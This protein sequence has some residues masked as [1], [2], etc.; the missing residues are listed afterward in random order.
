[1]TEFLTPLLVFLLPMACAA[2]CLGPTPTD[3]AIAVFTRHREFVFDAPDATL[4]SPRLFAA[5]GAEAACRKSSPGEVCTL[6]WDPWTDAQDG[7]ITGD[8]EV[9]VMGRTASSSRV[10]VRFDFRLDE[11]A[12]PQ[13]RSALLTFE[14][15]A[16][17]DCWLLADLHSKRAG[18]LQ[19]LSSSAVLSH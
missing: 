18:L 16:S 8:P 7:D 1:M 4:L 13:R 19:V 9:V 6:D 14:R 2:E 10:L 5:L 15:A 17:G 3:A 11:G 12:Q